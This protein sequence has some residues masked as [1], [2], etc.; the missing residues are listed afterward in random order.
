MQTFEFINAAT[1]S[2][3]K[4]SMLSDEF[5]KEL[6]ST[7]DINADCIQ[8]SSDKKVIEL[9]LNEDKY[10]AFNKIKNQLCCKGWKCFENEGMQCSS[11]SK[12]E[13]EIT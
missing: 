10:N 1:S 11:F 3:T 9:S 13:G 2:R 12:N 6:F 4:N 5:K 8:A 7:E